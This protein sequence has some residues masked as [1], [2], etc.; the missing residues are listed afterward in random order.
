MVSRRVVVVRIRVQRESARE[1]NEKGVQPGGN[2]R[3]REEEEDRQGRQERKRDRGIDGRSKG[4]GR[5]RN[6]LA[7]FQLRD[8]L[9]TG[10]TP[11][12][13]P[14]KHSSGRYGEMRGG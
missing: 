3:E 8:S 10:W 4:A 14:T 13:A 12:D 5:F 11:C 2:E 7:R 9:F 6:R 1:A